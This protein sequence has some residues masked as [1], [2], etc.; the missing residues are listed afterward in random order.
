MRGLAEEKIKGNPG[1]HFFL[2]SSIMLSMVLVFFFLFCA[3]QKQ[4]FL[5]KK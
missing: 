1:L 2:S 4:A 5:R 3:S